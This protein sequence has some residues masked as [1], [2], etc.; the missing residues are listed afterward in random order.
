MSTS[1]ETEPPSSTLTSIGRCVGA[2][3]VDFARWLVGGI[4]VVVGLGGIA[5]CVI[6]YFAMEAVGW[7]RVVGVAS[8][9]LVH[10][11]FASSIAWIAALALAGA[12]AIR[13]YEL[14]RHLLDAAIRVAVTQHPELARLRD[15]TDLSAEQ[16]AALRAALNEVS[17]R[18][19]SGRFG[20]IQ[21]VA[22]RTVSR[23]LMEALQRTL[24]MRP[25]PDDG[26]RLPAI[27][28]MLGRTIDDDLARSMKRNAAAAIVVMVALEAGLIFGVVSVANVFHGTTN[29]STIP[30][31]D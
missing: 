24:R 23:L 20:A 30:S 9:A 6:A 14:S 21:R 13:K 10:V 5:A 3:V 31:A 18:Y 15:S 2:F 8:A 17:G 1:T 22:L 27:A 7:A 25:L 11:T 4:A 19:S 12:T 26:M 29:A 28:E 16:I